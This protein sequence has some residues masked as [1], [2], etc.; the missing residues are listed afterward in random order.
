MT[1]TRSPACFTTPGWFKMAGASP[2][3]WHAGE[4]YRPRIA[5]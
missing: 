4:A 3:V 2:Y 5:G 1:Q